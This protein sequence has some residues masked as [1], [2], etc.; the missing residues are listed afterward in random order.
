M[1]LTRGSCASTNL[2]MAESNSA[3]TSR[4]TPPGI[5]DRTASDQA[6]FGPDP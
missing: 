5:G 2:V 1:C 3:F 6:T 4:T